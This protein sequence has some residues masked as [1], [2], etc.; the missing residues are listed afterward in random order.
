MNAQS[1]MKRRKFKL[2]IIL[3]KLIYKVSYN[4]AYIS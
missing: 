1:F 4:I 3:H 2:F